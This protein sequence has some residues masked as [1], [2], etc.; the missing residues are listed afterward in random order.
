[1]SIWSLK[2]TRL[3]AFGSSVRMMQEGDVACVM[4]DTY[5]NGWYPVHIGKKEML[6]FIHE[7]G[8]GTG[9]HRVI[10]THR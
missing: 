1:F 10:A 6:F 9:H 8:C 3:K 7:S 4:T 5:L 2:K